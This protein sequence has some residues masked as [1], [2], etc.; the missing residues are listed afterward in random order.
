MVIVD[1]NE[2]VLKRSEDTMDVM[3]VRGNGANAQT[4]AQDGTTA[5]H[6]AA[7]SGQVD[8]L[9][10]LLAAG[11]DVNAVTKDR[12]TPLMVAV[13]CGHTEAVRFLLANGA[14]SDIRDANGLTASQ[15]ALRQAKQGL[16]ET[17]REVAK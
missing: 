16:K 8:A 2:D 13:T 17:L 4:C 5:M 9:R 14:D 15:R 12:E 7:F 1:L 10:S 6:H 3:C 11:A